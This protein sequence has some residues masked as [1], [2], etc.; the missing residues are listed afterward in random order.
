MAFNMGE[1]VCERMG[2]DWASPFE[3]TISQQKVIA[4]QLH[5]SAMCDPRH[6]PPTLQRSCGV[7]CWSILI[8]LKGLFYHLFPTLLLT[9]NSC[10]HSFSS[11]HT[12]LSPSFSSLHT[13]HSLSFSSFHT[14]LSVS[15]S[16][17]HTRLSVSFSFL[18][19]HLSLS[20]PPFRWSLKY[21]SRMNALL[22]AGSLW[23]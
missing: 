1:D 23:L 19:T 16:S 17:L 2:C 4:S 15:F 3:S 22:S 14:R 11:L 10:L 6:A 12:R 18:R 21:S 5:L 8:T 9:H 7:L 20:L 13:H